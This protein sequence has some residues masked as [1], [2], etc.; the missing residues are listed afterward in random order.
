VLPFFDQYA[1]SHRV[2][3]RDSRSIVLP[4]ADIRP[5]PQITV[6]YADDSRSVE[7]GPGAIA[8]WSP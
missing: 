8:F 1:L 6:I 7:L 5:E 3:S 2:W 4:L